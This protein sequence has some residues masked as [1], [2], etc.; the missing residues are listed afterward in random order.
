MYLFLDRN[1]FSFLESTL[2]QESF[3]SLKIYIGYKS[4][5]ASFITNLAAG[6]F[7]FSYDFLSSRA[8]RKST[9]FLLGIFSLTL[10]W[11]LL[12]TA[13]AFH[14]P[15]GHIGFFYFEFGLFII[16]ICPTNCIYASQKSIGPDSFVSVFCD[17]HSILNL[18]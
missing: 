1:S 11:R 6:S 17:F 8:L 4:S 15:T 7:H 3:F 12:F 16:E 10:L 13:V 9:V 5:G 2:N 14:E 18:V